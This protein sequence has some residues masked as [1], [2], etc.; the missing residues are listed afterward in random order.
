MLLVCA[1]VV[2]Q[3]YVKEEVI[4]ESRTETTAKLTTLFGASCSDGIVGEVRHPTSAGVFCFAVA[5]PL[6][7]SFK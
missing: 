1:L 6:V 7:R 5:L 3:R 4:I 2:V